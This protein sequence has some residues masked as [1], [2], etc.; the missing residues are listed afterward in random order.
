MPI[1]IAC[2]S[3]S[4]SLK[5]ADT[6][7]GRAVKCPGCT[8]IVKVPGGSSGSNPAAT[9]AVSASS[10]RASA[11]APRPSGSSSN[12]A[13]KRS[14]PA[15]SPPAK[16]REEELDEVGRD[17]SMPSVE[18]TDSEV[19]EDMR[20]RVATEL[21]KGENLIWC[22]IPSRR[23]VLIRSLWGPFVGVFMLFVFGIMMTMMLAGG[24]GNALFMLLGIGVIGLCV[25]TPV[26]L[27]P[28]FALYRQKRTC[29]VLTNRR[30]IVWECGWFGGV[31][32]K[33][34]NPTQLTNM[35]RRDAWFGPKGGGD[36]IFHSVTTTSVTMTGGGGGRLQRIGH[37]RH[38]R[39]VGGTAPSV[40]VSQRTTHYGFMAIDKVG[41][42]ERLV[43]E[44]LLD[45]M[46]DKMIN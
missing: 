33:T 39:V 17:K 2:T 35:W 31:T 9:S 32:M 28:F 6:L 34:Y 19:P 24:G 3:C 21:S 42:I 13:A 43:R 45:R 7:A 46:M 38:A 15:Q 20:K 11:P 16:Q 14:A 10:P 4:K 18:L 5:V 41:E 37:T 22:G 12:D 44:T 26:I 23:I 1:S 27:S 36:L 40:N 30:C 29:Y 25:I 8:A